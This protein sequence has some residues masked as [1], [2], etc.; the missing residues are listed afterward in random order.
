MSKIFENMGI[1][2]VTHLVL[3]GYIEPC[4]N[5]TFMV[6]D[7]GAR[8]TENKCRLIT[9]C[10][11]QKEVNKDKSPST[12]LFYGNFYNAAISKTILNEA[13][14]MARIIRVML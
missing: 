5:L 12:Q 2:F 6:T 14:T 10:I 7:D 8:I 4:G 9:L 1:W 13:S 11:M 3:R